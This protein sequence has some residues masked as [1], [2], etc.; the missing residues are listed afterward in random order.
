MNLTL[1]SAPLNDD[2]FLQ[3]FHRCEL[4]L[5][6]FRHADHLRL[7]WLHLQRETLDQ[8]LQNVRTGI[9]RFAVHHGA[10]HIYH[11]TVTIAWVRLLASHQER[12]FAEFLQGNAY[13]LNAELLHRFWTPALLMSEQARQHWVPPDLHDLP[14]AA[15]RSF[16]I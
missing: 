12:S 2:A 16:T 9:R 1:A 15:P 8:A 14:A 4:P 10:G 6:Q 7:A 3:S 13:R 5:R 11:E